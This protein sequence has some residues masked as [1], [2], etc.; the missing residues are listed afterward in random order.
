MSRINLSRQ[1]DMVQNQDAYPITVIGAGA[2]GSAAAVNLAKMGFVVN[3]IDGDTVSS[4]NYAP[5]MFK[6]R[7]DAP[8]PTSVKALVEAMGGDS[9]S[10]VPHLRFADGKDVDSGGIVI[11]GVDSMEARR[12]LFRDRVGDP[13][14]YIDARI[15]GKS[16]TVFAIRGNDFEALAAYDR[17][18]DGESEDLPC[19]MKATAYTGGIAGSIIAYT[20]AQFVQDLPFPKMFH[21]DGNT[22]TVFT[23]HD[24]DN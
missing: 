22:A 18:L 2:I 24:Q 20:V 10:I 21:F 6:A 8:K 16:V 1:T 4:P 15:G 13:A 5:G 14:L 23:S 7:K 19:G 17:A 12:F 3:L 11:V 9:A